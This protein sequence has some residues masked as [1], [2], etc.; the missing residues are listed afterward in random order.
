MTDSRSA[1]QQLTSGGVLIGGGAFGAGLVFLKVTA[2]SAWDT[3][4]LL[5]AV[6]LASYLALL[7]YGVATFRRGLRRVPPDGDIARP[8]I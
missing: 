3:S 6:Q 8:A 2:A 4:R 7:A 1:R 5:G